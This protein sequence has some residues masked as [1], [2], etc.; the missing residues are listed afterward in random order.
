M[1]FAVKREQPLVDRV[2]YMQRDLKLLTR[3][4]RN[5]NVGEPLAA[6]TVEQVAALRNAV[7]IEHGMHPLLPLGPLM[8][9]QMPGPHPRADIQNV[10]GRDPRLRDPTDQQ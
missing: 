3:R 2:D 4:V 1:Q 6:C 7:V 5:S 8:R 9:Q 10:C